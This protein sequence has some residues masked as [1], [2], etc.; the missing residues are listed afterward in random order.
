LEN[1]LAQG[2]S[3]ITLS[4]LGGPKYIP[5]YNVMGVAKAALEST[6]RYMAVELGASKAIRVNAISAGP[7]KTLA[8]SG[9]GDFRQILNWNECNAP[10]RKNVSI[11]EVGNSALYLLSD[12]ASGVSGEVH[13]VDAGYNIMG[14]PTVEKNSEGK[15]VMVWE[16]RG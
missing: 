4:Y 13:Y 2:A 16:N 3:V 6:V 9:I 7:I 5:N 12:L 8:A 11:Q 14:M 10:L 1:V 15:T